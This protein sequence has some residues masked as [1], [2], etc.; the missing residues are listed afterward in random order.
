MKKK[1]TGYDQVQDPAV[2]NG[3]TSSSS[4]NASSDSATAFLSCENE[5]VMVNQDGDGCFVAASGGSSGVKKSSASKQ[6]TSAKSMPM[7]VKSAEEHLALLAS[8]VASY[9]N[10]IQGKISD[11]ATLD[12]DYDQID[13]D[14][15]EEMDLQWQMAM[16]S[17]RVKRFM[18]RT[19]RK[20]VGRSV[21]FDKAKVRC[22]NCQSY[23]H[24]ARE[25]QKQKQDNSSQSSNNRNASSNS[26]SKALISTA[27]EGSYDWS[28]HLE[29]DG[30][31]TQAFM[32]EITPVDDGEAKVDDAEVKEDAEVKVE[33]RA[34]EKKVDQTTGAEDEKQ[35]SEY[36]REAE[37]KDAK[38]KQ[39]EAQLAALM[40]NLDKQTGEV[41]SNSVC[42]KFRELQGEVDRLSAQNKSLVSEMSNIKESNFFAKRNETSYLKK[43]KGYESEI[44]AVTCKLNEKLQVIDLAHDMMAEKTKEISD[45]NK[46]LSDAQLRIVELEK[47]L[48]QFRDSTFVMKHMMGGLKKSNDKTSVGFQGYNEVPPPLSH[49]YSFLP[50]ED[51]LT[52]FMSTAPSSSTASRGDESERGDTKKDNN[53][54]PALKKNTSQPKNKNS[55]FAKKINFVQGSDMKNET[56]VI[57]NESNIEFAKNKNKETSEIKQTEPNP[58]MASSSKPESSSKASDKKSSK[59]MSC[60]KYHTK[61]HVASCCPNKNNEAQVNERKREKSP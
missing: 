36:E 60:F 4:H 1:D 61:G 29:N 9:E 47:Q 7:S 24:F 43:I 18:N 11:P 57:E 41:K 44:E 42:L 33:N 14:D 51:E 59:R 54:K 45:K 32:A 13:P 26:S 28:I 8:F 38:Y 27:R 40:A 20:F 53:S 2:Y 52:K 17:R 10:Y 49:D 30:N 37:E 25:C 16:I 35:K 46:E 12:E 50:D 58:S 15:L 34:E 31:V 48:G 39:L 21:G 19:G 56:S 6:S 23:G 55:T 22:F 5:Q 3:L